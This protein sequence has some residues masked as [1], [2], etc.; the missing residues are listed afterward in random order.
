VEI[1]GLI[2][3][4]DC[5]RRGI[6]RELVE[7]IERWANQLGIDTVVVRS[8]V[9]RE[10]SRRFYPA[11]GYGVVKTQEVFRKRL[12]LEADGPR[13]KV[14]PAGRDRAGANSRRPA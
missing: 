4:S 7:E 2:V 1:I 10:E 11:V 12:V 9:Q 6:A 5:R 13:A 14:M 3:A 8:N